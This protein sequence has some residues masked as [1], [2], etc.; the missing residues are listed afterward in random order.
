M[1]NWNAAWRMI[2]DWRKGEGERR[3]VMIGAIVIVLI[4]I[5]LVAYFVFTNPEIARL[6]LEM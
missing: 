4:T 5:V 1:D 6:L 3:N 2:D